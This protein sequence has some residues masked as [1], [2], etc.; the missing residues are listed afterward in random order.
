MKTRVTTQATLAALIISVSLLIAHPAWAHT[1]IKLSRFAEFTNSYGV[2]AH[3]TDVDWSGIVCGGSGS[4][5]FV[6][7]AIQVI[8]DPQAEGDAFVELGYEEH[9]TGVGS[10]SCTH[11]QFYYWIRYYNDTF[12]SNSI[13]SVTAPGTHEF[14]LNRLQTGCAAGISWC[15][16]VKIDGETKTTTAGD[17]TE[18]D[19]ALENDAF[20]FCNIHSTN[21]CDPSGLV[22]PVNQLTYKPVN[23]GGGTWP[24]WSGRDYECSDYGSKA[25]AKWASDTS[26]KAGFNVTLS[27]AIQND[28]C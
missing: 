5:H 8:G 15:W 19:P 28:P 27:G 22:D 23:F 13:D 14:S 20:V 7:T 2:H 10:G 21:D 16:N 12:N 24:D 3:W 1:S 25:R 6:D 18:L 11:S 26:F 17:E 4:V 9:K